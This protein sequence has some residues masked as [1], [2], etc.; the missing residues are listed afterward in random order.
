MK[1]T[2]ITELKNEV[3]KSQKMC[4]DKDTRVMVNQSVNEFYTRFLF[5]IYA[6]PLDVALPSDISATFF[7]NLSPDGREFLISEGVQVPPSP[8]PENNHYGNQRLLLVR[9]AAL[10]A[11]NKT[12]TIKAEVKIVSESCHPKTFIR[13][14]GGKPST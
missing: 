6:L 1:R 5:K 9:N 2:T 11:E 8:P 7:N 12:S 14:L 10:E 3:S 4:Y 13:M